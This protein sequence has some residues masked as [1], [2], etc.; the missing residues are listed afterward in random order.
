MSEQTIAT[1]ETQTPQTEAA[2]LPP[3]DV[4]EDSA[5]I[6]LYADLPGVAKDQLNLRVEAETL[7]IEG[8]L[9][10]TLPE[11]MQASHAEVSLPRYRRVFTL[12]RELDTE[13]VSAEFKQGVLTLRIPKTA[14]AQPHRI[15][16]N[17]A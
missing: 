10:L 2:L 4:I 17:V 13:K 8:Q 15:A 5:G 11:G 9:S 14:Q 16:I 7:T 1:Q 6:T 3:V 12:S